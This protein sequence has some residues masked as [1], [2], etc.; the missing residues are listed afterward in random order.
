MSKPPAE[1]TRLITLVREVASGAKELGEV[2]KWISQRNR[3]V[4]GFEMTEAHISSSQPQLNI[5][6]RG[7]DGKTAYDIAVDAGNGELMKILESAGAHTPKSD[8]VRGVVASPAVAYGSS[9]S[10]GGS[11]KSGK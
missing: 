7:S 10:G 5:N 1:D 4:S 9:R 3:R 6:A 11:A 8:E 2:T